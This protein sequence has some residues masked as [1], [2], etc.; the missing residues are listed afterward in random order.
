M[1]MLRLLLGLTLTYQSH[2]ASER[3]F[4]TEEQHEDVLNGVYGYSFEVFYSQ[5]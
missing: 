1:I 2:A 5:S 4:F 3:I